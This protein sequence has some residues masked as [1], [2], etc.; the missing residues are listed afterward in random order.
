MSSS[1]R[2]MVFPLPIPFRRFLTVKHL[3]LIAVTKTAKR[4]YRTL[5]FSSLLTRNAS[6]RQWSKCLGRGTKTKK[7]TSSW[8]K[9]GQRRKSIRKWR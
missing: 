2:L 5:R 7:K 1:E 6:G 8:S 4:R 3:P 9:E